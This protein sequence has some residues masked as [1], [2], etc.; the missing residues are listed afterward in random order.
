MFVLHHQFGVKIEI[1]E[2]RDVDEKRTYTKKGKKKRKEE[3]GEEEIGRRRNTEFRDHAKRQTKNNLYAKNLAAS[4]IY[5]QN[6][7]EEI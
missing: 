6:P 1:L 7:Y 3:A 2:Q 5:T 4:D